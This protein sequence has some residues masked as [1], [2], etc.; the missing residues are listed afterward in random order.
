MEESEDEMRELNMAGEIGDYL[1]N[2]KERQWG[3]VA[4][5]LFAAVAPL[6]AMYR[7]ILMEDEE[8]H[9]PLGVVN[10]LQMDVMREGLPDSIFLNVHDP[11]GNVTACA[12]YVINESF[13]VHI[14][15]EK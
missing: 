3:L 12:A 6:A 7:E 10:A 1:E 15:E 5:P 11:D 13:G 14:E 2:V 9:A 8:A 4:S